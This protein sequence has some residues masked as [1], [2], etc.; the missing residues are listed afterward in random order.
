MKE[1]NLFIPGTQIFIKVD[2]GFQ[3]AQE[4]FSALGLE[5]KIIDSVSG[6]W[7]LPALNFS[8]LLEQP[9]DVIRD[10][11]SERFS[12]VFDLIQ[13]VLD[14][15]AHKLENPERNYINNHK[16]DHSL[17]VSRA[18]EDILRKA[19]GSGRFD[20]TDKTIA[21]AAIAGMVHDF[22]SIFSGKEGHAAYSAAMLPLL[23]SGVKPEDKSHWH[24]LFQAVYTHEI[25]SLLDGLDYGNLTPVTQALLFADKMDIGIFRV[26]PRAQE[27]SQ[28]FS[29]AHTMVNYFIEGHTCHLGEGNLGCFFDFSLNPGKYLL[30]TSPKLVKNGQAKLRKYPSARMARH[31]AEKSYLE[32][33]YEELIGI[34]P[35]RL[36]VAARAAFGL[37]GPEAI[38]RVSFYFVDDSDTEK[39]YAQAITIEISRNDILKLEAFPQTP[40]V[41]FLSEKSQIGQLSC[42][43]PKT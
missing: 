10:Q 5:Q 17:A 12:P 7:L 31:K 32:S 40:L 15:N 22:G 42:V 41:H 18:M 25:G 30:Q 3:P 19:K 37:F 4:H 21:C 14:K 16:I 6:E 13:P 27:F 35:K 20:I 43:L 34:Y 1:G 28:V 39:G 24:S 26:N 36:L 2:G 8:E 33:Y 9:P 38:D 23:F 29:E 11:I